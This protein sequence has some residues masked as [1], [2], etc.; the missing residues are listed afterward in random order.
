M[1]SA[2]VKIDRPG[3]SDCTAVQNSVRR[4][5]KSATDEPPK[6]HEPRELTYFLQVS[7][8]HAKYAGGGAQKFGRP[9]MPLVDTILRYNQRERKEP[10]KTRAQCAT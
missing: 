5:L 6:L 4:I 1:D 7:F 3:D 9:Y 2:T 8:P 10:S